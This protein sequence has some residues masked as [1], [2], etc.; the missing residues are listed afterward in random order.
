M[1]IQRDT[2]MGRSHNELYSF[3]RHKTIYELKVLNQNLQERT[4]ENKNETN[5]V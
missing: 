1:Q 4:V 2:E 3:I 5:C